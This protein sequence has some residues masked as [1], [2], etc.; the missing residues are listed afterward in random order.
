MEPTI[1]TIKKRISLRGYESDEIAA[2][3][4]AWGEPRYR[5]Q[6]VCDFLFSPKYTSYDQCSALPKSLLVKMAGAYAF[7]SLMK[8]GEATALDRQTTK[9]LFATHDGHTLETVLIKSKERITVCLSTQIGCRFG[10]VF[11]MSGSKGF[12]RDLDASEIVDQIYLV[13]HYTGLTVTNIVV[14]GMGEPFDNYDETIKAVRVCH[15]AEGFNLGARHITLST[16]GVPDGI[17]RLAREGLDQIKLAISLHAPTQ[18]LRARLM[19]ISRK[20][21]LEALVEQILKNREAFK[22]S[23]TLEYVLLSG[24]NDGPAEAAA[25]AGL[26]KKIK[27]KV[28][29]IP[30][31]KNTGLEFEGA[32]LK[33]SSLNKTKEFEAVLN[34]HKVICTVRKSTGGDI[35]AAC[36]Q[37]SCG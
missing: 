13:S 24:I 12:I 10:C 2:L 1:P 35:A 8:K 19:P 6:Q 15:S 7:V 25:L 4:E 20:Y 32:V 33:G 11:C 14:M 28:N 22:R 29:L 16:A 31:N 27:A 18:A 3:I 9:Y 34:D 30:Y 21:T 5:A 26:A 23:I 37:L 36:G 17:A